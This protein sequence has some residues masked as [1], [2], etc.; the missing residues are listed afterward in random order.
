M[1]SFTLAALVN[2]GIASKNL[3]QVNDD[4]E[5]NAEDGFC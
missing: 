3:N 5:F 4:E 2:P 1:I